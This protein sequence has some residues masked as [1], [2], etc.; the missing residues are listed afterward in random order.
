VANLC[1]RA[2]FSSAL[3]MEFP[4]NRAR[5]APFFALRQ[6]KPYGINRQLFRGGRAAPGT[7][8]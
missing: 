8:Q 5:S 1:S 2:A 6:E 4:E 7:L 3:D